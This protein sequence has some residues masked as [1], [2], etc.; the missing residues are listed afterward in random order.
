MCI[1][2]SEC[3]RVVSPA[4]TCT[5][6]TCEYTYHGTKSIMVF[7]PRHRSCCKVS[8]R[9][10]EHRPWCRVKRGRV[11]YDSFHSLR[12]LG[13]E[14]SK[15]ADEGPKVSWCRDAGLA[16]VTAFHPK[17][18]R[19]IPFVK[20]DNFV[21]SLCFHFDQSKSIHTPLSKH[22]ALTTADKPTHEFSLPSP[23]N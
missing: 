1:S 5:P 3:F 7:R 21:T 2:C 10:L 15:H 11:C 19:G 23:S 14:R 20:S 6:S 12:I 17:V 16:S 18:G 22:P 4:T 13:H 8:I 9:K